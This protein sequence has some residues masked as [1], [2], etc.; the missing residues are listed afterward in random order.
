MDLQEAIDHLKK[1]IRSAKGELNALKNVHIPKD[2]TTDYIRGH[3]T[4][5][6]NLEEAISGYESTLRDYESRKR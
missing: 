4:K 3:E 6:R 5:I 1:N 2:S